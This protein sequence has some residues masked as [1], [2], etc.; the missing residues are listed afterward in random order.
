M[1]DEGIRL[2]TR[3]LLLVAIIL[4]TAAVRTLVGPGRQRGRVMAAGTLGGLVV[5]VLGSASLSTWFGT[6]VSTFSALAGIILGWTI[7][8][9]FARRFPRHAN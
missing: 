1:S 3:L 7:A 5:G 2:V 6:D 4:L 8:W 9:P